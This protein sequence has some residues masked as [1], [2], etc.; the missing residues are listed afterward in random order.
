MD[1]NDVFEKIRTQDVST[2]KDMRMGVVYA[3]TTNKGRLHEDIK[4]YTGMAFIDVDNCTD[5]KRVKSIFKDVDCTIA[6]WYSTSGNVHALIKIPVC[7]SK[8]EFKRRYAIL[9]NDLSAYIGD[10]G[11]FDGITSNP[12]Q[13]AFTSSDKDI[14][15][16]DNPTT[17]KGIYEATPKEPVKRLL[18]GGYSD[19]S[20]KWCINKAEDWFTSISSNGYPQ[21]LRYSYTIGG[22]SAGGYI[23]ESDAL[24][25]ITALVNNN[26]YINS[27]ESS[28][29]LRTYL[30]GA[31]E[32]FNSGL[33]NPISW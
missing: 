2:P 31:K 18:V 7:K 23:S 9:Q 11:E 29:S 21:V 25:T 32:S 22:W 14:Y 5:A 10:L 17:Y 33:D 12:T 6:C 26:P 1:L 27:K 4:S 20:T 8:D 30:N 16:N 28:G 15:I 24:E 19:A 13:L 3:T